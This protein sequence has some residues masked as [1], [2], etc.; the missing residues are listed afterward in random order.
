MTLAQFR[1]ALLASL[2]RR[3][4]QARVTV[5]ESRGVSLTC[6]AE[7]SADIF[8]SVYFNALT[9]KTSY[10]LIQGDRRL[11]GCDNYRFWH[12]H[13][14]GVTDQHIPCPPLTPDEASAEL[15]AAVKPLMNSA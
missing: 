11:A 8:I 10:A 12:R 13:P 3:L 7:V 1:Q 9:D 5:T 14:S 4:P 15:A 2:N 6:R